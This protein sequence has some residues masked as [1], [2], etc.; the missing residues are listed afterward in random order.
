[1]PQRFLRPGIVT[2]KRFNACSWLGQIFYIRLLTLVDDFGRYDADPVI[3]KSHAFPLHED[4]RSS[5][6]Q[7]LCEELQANQLATFYES[8]G[9]SVL[10][11]TR[12]IEKRRAE[13]S[14]F[15]AF[16]DKCKQLYATDSTCAPSPSSPSP[17]SSPSGGVQ[18]G[19]HEPSAREKR[20][21]ASAAPPR[22]DSQSEPEEE[23]V[24]GTNK[25]TLNYALSW[26]AAHGR[27]T[28]DRYAAEE[29]REAY[30]QFNAACDKAGNWMWGKK[31]AGD[32]RS[33]LLERMS[34]N[35]E[36]RGGKRPPTNAA[37][38]LVRAINKV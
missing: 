17:P 31:P 3:L 6:V 30:R 38:A 24:P 34:S 15:P 29:V 26:T 2:S 23:G 33:A 5:Q 11:L 14:K 36:K 16:D 32:W 28:G 8:D 1:M 19:S 7:K 37:D 12:W 25:P 4:L 27:K 10:E 18:R 13:K 9:K 21:G 20:N 35:R 22:P